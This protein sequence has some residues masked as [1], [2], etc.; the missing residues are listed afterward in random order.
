MCVI[1]LY[2]NV[3]ASDDGWSVGCRSEDGIYMHLRETSV[4]VESEFG[5]FHHFYRPLSPL[6][7]IEV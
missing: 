2:G 5:R 4:R 7:R 6:G 1:F 3:R